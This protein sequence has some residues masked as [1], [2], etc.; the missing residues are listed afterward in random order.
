MAPS[1]LLACV[2]LWADARQGWSRRMESAERQPPFPALQDAI[3]RRVFAE[4]IGD[5]SG[6]GRLASDMREIWTTQPRFENVSGSL[7]SGW[8]TSRVSGRL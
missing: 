3:D 1:F 5:V 6:G 8:S 4:R 2:F 7:P